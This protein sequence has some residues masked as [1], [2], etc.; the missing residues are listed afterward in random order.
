MK[1]KDYQIAIF[2]DNNRRELKMKKNWERE[3]DNE[4]FNKGYR[5][6]W[7]AHFSDIHSA[8]IKYAELNAFPRIY[9]EKIIRSKN[10]NWMSLAFDQ[11][12]KKGT[13]HSSK[14]YPVPYSF[15]QQSVLISA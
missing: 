6:V 5:C 11:A 4:G 15:F 8:E 10:P 7:V 12:N 3:E 14:N 9:L 1:T 13:E 2:T